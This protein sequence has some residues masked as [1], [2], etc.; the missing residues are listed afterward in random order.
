[1]KSLSII[2]GVL[3][4]IAS[5]AQ[6]PAPHGKVYGLKPSTAG[7]QDATK[8]NAFMTGKTRISTTVRGRVIKV[9]NP[10]GGWF[11]IDAGNGNVIAAHFKNAGINVPASL[12]GKYVIAEGVASKQFIADDSQHYAGDTATAKKKHFVKTDPKNALKFEVR[13]LMVEK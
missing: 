13:G 7:M 12:K 6:T 10:I 9:T 1:M 2:F 8:L 4:S 3:I 11:D 5:Y